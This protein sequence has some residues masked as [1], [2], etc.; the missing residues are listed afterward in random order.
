MVAAKKISLG[1][2]VGF[3]KLGAELDDSDRQCDLAPEKRTP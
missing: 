3:V 1:F 2:D